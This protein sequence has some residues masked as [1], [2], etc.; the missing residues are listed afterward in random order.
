M[1]LK[2]WKV[3]CQKSWENDYDYIPIDRFAKTGEC[4]YTIR[5][6]NK[7]IYIEGTPQTKPFS[8]PIN[9]VFN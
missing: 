8:N 7:S 4:R 9:V 2:E 5:N 6:C 1:N 3:L